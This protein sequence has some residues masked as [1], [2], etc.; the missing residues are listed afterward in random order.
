MGLDQGNLFQPVPCHRSK[1]SVIYCIFIYMCSLLAVFKIFK[2]KNQCLG[3]ADTSV[4]FI[5][6]G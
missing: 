6:W 3:K 4:A 5:D 1:K 2:I